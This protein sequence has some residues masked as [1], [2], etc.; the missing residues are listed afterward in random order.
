M[1]NSTALLKLALFFI[2]TACSLAPFAPTNSARSLGKGK[3]EAQ[4]GRANENFFMKYA[5]GLSQNFDFGFV[6]EFGTLS[7]T[8]IYGKYAIQNKPL[9]L[10]W[11]LEGGY[12]S[13]NSTQFFYF[14]S[15]ASYA[16]STSLDV[17]FNGRFNKSKTEDSTVEL[18]RANGNL[19]ILEHDLNYFQFSYGLNLWLTEKAGIAL[20]NTHFRGE[21][22][23]TNQDATFGAAFLYRL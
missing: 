8:A 15:T 14:G 17:F 19:I 9:G 13:S 16:F 12:G 4:A 22:I 5:I 1:L 6:T 2:L 7:T 18:G 23:K 10:S 20:F 3:V 11:G 21:E